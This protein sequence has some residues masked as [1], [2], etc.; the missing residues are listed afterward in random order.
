MLG[1]SDRNKWLTHAA[2]VLSDLK[3][4]GYKVSYDCLG[5]LTF[6]RFENKV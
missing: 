1:D 2:T 6:M 5:R 4:L 3:A